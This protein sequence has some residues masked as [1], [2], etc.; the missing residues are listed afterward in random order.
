MARVKVSTH[1]L[2]AHHV[3][4]LRDPATK[5]PEFRRAVGQITRLV[6][7]EATAS[8]ATA[9]LRVPTPLGTAGGLRIAD[10]IA[11]VPILRAGLG[12]AEGLLELIPD[13]E[14]WHVGLYRDEATLRPQEYYN[15]LPASCAATVA[16]VVDPMLA[17]GG[18]AVRTCEILRAAGIPR[19][20][21]LAI[22]A[23]PEGVKR[24]SEAMPDVAIHVAALDEGLDANG[25]I[26]PGLG[27]AGDRQ[28]ATH[29]RP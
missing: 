13:A 14:V 20:I 8:L 21:F 17:T 11:I 18:S 22:I 5:P 6:A 9:D 3:A 29:A 12:M 26:V 19:V 28:F 4:A 1:P 27:D 25:Y 23:A 24:L 7:V 16:I 2:V 15:K 10:R